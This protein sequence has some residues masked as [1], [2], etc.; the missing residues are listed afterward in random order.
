MPALVSVVRP[1]ALPAAASSLAMHH[2]SRRHRL[3]LPRRET[4][5]AERASK[6]ARLSA[7]RMLSLTPVRCWSPYIQHAP[8]SARQRP[9]CDRH[10]CAASSRNGD[11]RWE[12]PKSP[13]F[14]SESGGDEVVTA[15]SGRRPAEAKECESRSRVVISFEVPTA[16]WVRVGYVIISRCMVGRVLPKVEQLA[17]VY[18]GSGTGLPPMPDPPPGLVMRIYTTAHHR[19]GCVARMNT[20]RIG[21]QLTANLN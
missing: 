19:P 17:Q 15:P 1:A 12:P 5:N 9:R 3:E 14:G 16:K 7:L 21:H 13:S 4:S 8:T 18:V 10:R 11:L 6:W 20:L 2:H